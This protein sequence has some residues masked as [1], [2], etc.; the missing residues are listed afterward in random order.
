MVDLSETTDPNAYGQIVT[1]LN[2]TPGVAGTNPSPE[3]LPVIAKIA[4]AA[5]QEAANPIQVMAVYPTTAPQDAAT[6]E[7]LTTLREDVN[8][9]LEQATGATI[10]VGGTAAITADF[11]TCWQTHCRSS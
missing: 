11:T 9:A 10:L 3:T 8:P 6:S 2:E 1:T 7:L 4:Q 5:P